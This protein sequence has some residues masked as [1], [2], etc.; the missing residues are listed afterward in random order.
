MIF[1]PLRGIN[2]LPQISQ[3]IIEKFTL[4]LDHNYGQNK[5]SK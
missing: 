5:I 2:D 4:K 1:S 3:I